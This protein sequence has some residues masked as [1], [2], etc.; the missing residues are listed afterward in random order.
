MASLQLSENSY[1]Q[2]AESVTEGHPDKLCDQI[3]D[4]ILDAILEEDPLGRVA[5]ET[6]ATT[7]LII[8][9][10]EITT[11]C[12]VDIPKIVRNTVRDVG[13]IDDE[14]GFNYKTCGVMVEIT[15]QSLDIAAGVDIALEVRES[16]DPGEIDMVGAGDQGIMVGYACNETENLMP[17]PI[18][19]AHQLTKDLAGLRQNNVLRYLRPDGKSQVVVEYENGKPKRVD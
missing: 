18:S 17:L 3:S 12:Y 15:E 9:L 13:Y 6:V 10:G 1:L 8:I 19:L 14:Y 16:D 11:S 5:C 7:G 4:A 2:T